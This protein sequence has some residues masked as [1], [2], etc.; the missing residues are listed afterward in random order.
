[1]R[2]R[3]KFSTS[4]AIKVASIIE[5]FNPSFFEEPVSPENV[6]EMA[7]VAANT[8]ISIAQLASSV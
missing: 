2:P 5:E 1:M 4:G 3:G 6:D 7:R 8:S